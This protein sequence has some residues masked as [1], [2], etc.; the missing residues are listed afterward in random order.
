MV[1]YRR[2]LILRETTGARRE[3]YPVVLEFNQLFPDIESVNGHSPEVVDD[4]GTPV[5]SQVDYI[6]FSRTGRLKKWLQS[7]GG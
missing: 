6:S 1:W 7:A 3:R 5:P 2:N 4:R